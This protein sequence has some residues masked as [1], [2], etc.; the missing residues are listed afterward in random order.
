MLPNL[1]DGA[2]LNKIPVDQP[3]VDASS[4]SPEGVTA[5]SHR[6]WLADGCL[7]MTALFW[8]INIP[9]VKYA[10]GQVDAFA[11]NSVRLVFATLILAVFAA[12]ESRMGLSIKG[13]YSRV[14]WG[15][16]AMLNGFLYMVLFMFGVRATTAGN[17]ALLLSSMPV[18][19][20]IFS[21]LF[22]K[23]RLPKITWIGLA[24]TITGTFTVILFGKDEVS[25]GAGYL[26]GNL[27]ML[28]AA[29]TWA[30]GTVISRKLL[31]SVGPMT[32]AF[33]S[34]LVTTPI[35]LLIA[36]PQIAEC[37]P[38][39]L[40]THVV[41]AILYSGLGSTGIAYALWHVGVR[42]LGGSHASVYQNMVTLV[43][44]LGGWLFLP[45]SPLVAQIAGGLLI[46]AGIFVMRKGRR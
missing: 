41:L 39:L 11:F 40:Q 36:A 28:I 12:I 31:E 38:Q 19:T 45:E 13:P 35:H 21:F 34:S 8:G 46:V 23:E 42:Q 32:L 30:S 4:V 33:W 15:V 6:N 26:I 29:M 37:W 17:V 25:L 16:F 9:V 14:R 43:A 44:V 22:L 24:I 3:A 1:S 7:F 2:V 20:A 27:L 18:W 5:G 10:V